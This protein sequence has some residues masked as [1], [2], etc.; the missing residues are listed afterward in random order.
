MLLENLNKFLP[1]K[2]IKICSE[3]QA[4]FTAALKKLDRRCKREYSK[5]K[6][7]EKWKTL[8]QLFYEKCSEA[9]KE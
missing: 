5:N 6:K 3:D 9:K 1:L 2:T 7:S 8:N 4:W